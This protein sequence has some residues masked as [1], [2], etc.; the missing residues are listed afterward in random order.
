[1][2]GEA[3]SQRVWGNVFDSDILGVTLDHEPRK[4]PRER[5]TTMQKHIRRRL[6]NITRFHC[7]V[8]LQPVN[9]AFAHRHAAN[10]VSLSVTL[11]E[12]LHQIDISLLQ[13]HELRDTQAGGIHDF[14]YRT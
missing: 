14:K 9:S 4:L 6:I 5:S 12:A 1:M 7:R 10:F 8:L 13:I 3:V 2:S 11:D